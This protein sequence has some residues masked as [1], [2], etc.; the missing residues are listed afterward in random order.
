MFEG[1]IHLHMTHFPGKVFIFLLGC[2]V[3]CLTFI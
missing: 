3:A 2:G 1:P